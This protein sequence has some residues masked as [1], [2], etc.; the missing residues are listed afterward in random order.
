MKKVA[1]CFAEEYFQSGS[2][3]IKEGDVGSR[4]YIIKSGTVS[5]RKDDAQLAELSAGESFGEISLLGNKARNAGKFFV[6]Q[7]VCLSVYKK[8]RIISTV[9]KLN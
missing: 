7:A 2:T 3:V 1:Q 9:L 8:M 6:R 5:I 4:F